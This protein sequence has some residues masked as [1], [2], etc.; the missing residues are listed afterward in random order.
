MQE[1]KLF[2]TQS[3]FYM[4]GWSGNRVY[5]VLKID[6]FDASEIT[7]KIP[8]PIPKKN[9]TSCLNGYTKTTRPQAASN[10]SVS[11]MA[12]LGSLSFGDHT[13]CGHRVYEVS[14]SEIISLRNSCVLSN[15][16]NSRDENRYKKLLCMVDLTKNFFFSYYF[17]IMRS[18]MRIYVTMRVVIFSI[19]KCLCGTCS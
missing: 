6:R 9:A 1:F 5:R 17:S 13:T 16:A 8:L 14:K 7:L 2:E 4:I 19:R 11:V 18:S 3:N 12:S 10:W 15:I